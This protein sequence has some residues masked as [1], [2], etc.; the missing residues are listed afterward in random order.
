MTPITVTLDRIP[1]PDPEPPVITSPTATPDT[2]GPGQSKI[3][4]GAHVTDNVGVTLVSIG[5]Y[6]KGK[7]H[8]T[9]DGAFWSL[10]LFQG[11]NK[12]C[13]Y[14]GEYTF[15]DSVPDGEYDIRYFGKDSAQN[16]VIGGP[17]TVTLDR[18]P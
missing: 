10:G 8:T 1:P 17:I 4:L 12:N 16:Q 14:S 11:D 2:L 9:I 7:T 3:T 6:E 18:I 13:Q 5:V 15:T